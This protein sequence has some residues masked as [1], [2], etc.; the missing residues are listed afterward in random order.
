MGDIALAIPVV[1]SV[2]RCNPDREFYFVTRPHPSRLFVNPPANLHLIPVDL[3]RYKGV[4]GIWR[5]ARELI[6]GRQIGLLADL[7][8]VLRTKMLRVMLGLQ[9]VRCAHIDK[10]RSEKRALTR[11]ENKQL[12]QLPT[13]VSRYESV[14]RQLGLTFNLDFKSIFGPNG[15]AAEDF[16]SVVAPKTTGEFWLAVAPFAQHRGK[17]YPLEQLREVVAHFAQQANCRVFI[18][19]FGEKE[20]AKIARLAEGLPNVVNMAEARIGMA[21]ELS[22][23][24]HCNVMLSM[25]SANMHLAS[26]VGLRTVSIWGA[27]HPYAGFLGWRQR[28]EDCVQLDMPCRPCSIYGNRPCMRGDYEC[29]KGI[30]ARSV[31]E[32]LQQTP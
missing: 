29:L 23:L 22:L 17:V 9:G 21:A 13:T 8:D 26:L 6:Q 32:R 20:S 31:I 4:A 11:A 5:L 27:T 2:A 18:F 15:G 19:G 25:D 3:D 30:S 14:F 16:A 10:G 7:H 1:Y 24:N 28:A 12:H